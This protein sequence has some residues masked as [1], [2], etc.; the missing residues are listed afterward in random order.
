MPLSSFWDIKGRHTLL[1][2][3]PY[4]EEHWSVGDEIDQQRRALL[5][6]VELALASKI[7]SIEVRADSNRSLV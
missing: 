6:R 7:V 3:V 5:D 2:G 1:E 4:S